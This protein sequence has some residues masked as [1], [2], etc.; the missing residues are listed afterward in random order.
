MNIL[1]L[2]EGHSRVTSYSYEVENID[3]IGK[4]GSKGP[5]VLAWAHAM[6]ELLQESADGFLSDEDKALWEMNR[7]ALLEEM[8]P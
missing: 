4:F 8:K 1:K 3:V 7:D 5:E 2:G 6:Q